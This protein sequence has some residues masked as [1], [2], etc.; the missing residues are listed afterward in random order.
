MNENTPEKREPA[1]PDSLF[2]WGPNIPLGFM[3]GRIEDAGIPLPLP[4]PEKAVD[5]EEVVPVPVRA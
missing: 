4:K 1:A 2:I 5:G 3:T